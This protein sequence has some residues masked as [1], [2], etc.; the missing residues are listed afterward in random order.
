MRNIVV[1]NFN[2]VR[3]II[4]LF[5]TI[6]YSPSETNEVL[7]PFVTIALCFVICHIQGLPGPVG[8]MG[9]KGIRVSRCCFVLLKVNSSRK[10]A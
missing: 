3:Y 1:R 8:K 2:L 9:P 5:F 7:P 10:Y 4:T 6:K